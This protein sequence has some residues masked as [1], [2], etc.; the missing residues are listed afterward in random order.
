LSYLKNTIND[1]S[2]H[3][4]AQLTNGGAFATHNKNHEILVCSH[5]CGGYGASKNLLIYSR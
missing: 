5:S 2:A 1:G 4:D 3:G